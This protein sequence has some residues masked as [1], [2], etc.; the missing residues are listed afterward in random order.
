MVK[1]PVHIQND[2]FPDVVFF[3]TTEIQH[4][5][6]FDVDNDTCGHVQHVG[7][8]V[9]TQLG[10]LPKFATGQGVIFVNLVYRINSGNVALEM[11]NP[12]PGLKD[13]QESCLL[14]EECK[15]LGTTEELGMFVDKYE[16]LCISQHCP[17]FVSVKG[18]NIDV[19]L[20]EIM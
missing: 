8:D 15:H 18:E 16:C 9:T 1:L 20:C 19:D 14:L 11:Y 4:R 17:L 13:P 10:F 7:D 6:V 2:S 3:N 5:D 12:V